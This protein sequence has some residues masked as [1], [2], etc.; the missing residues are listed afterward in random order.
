M[1]HE[2]FTAHVG[3]RGRFVLPADVRRRLHLEHGDLLV[4]DV[5]DDED[6]LIVRKATGVARGFLGIYAGSAPGR[7]LAAELL[8]GRR[9]E[10][11]PEVIVRP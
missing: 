3:D 1:T 6:A 8:E 7:D 11:E 9:A 4:I 10:A 5:D 2:R